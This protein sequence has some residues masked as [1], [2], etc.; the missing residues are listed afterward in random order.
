MLL[1]IALRLAWA[2]AA[3]DL[4]PRRRP[5]RLSCR[6]PSSRDTSTTTTS[7]V[8]GRSSPSSWASGEPF[9]LPGGL[10]GLPSYRAMC[11]PNRFGK[12]SGNT[13]GKL[14]TKRKRNRKSKKEEQECE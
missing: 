13:W 6:A 1:P 2:P 7:Q 12:P 5:R 8:G 3:R 10:S 14:N 4:T 11:S 9:G